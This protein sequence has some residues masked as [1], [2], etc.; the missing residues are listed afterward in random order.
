MSKQVADGDV[1]S[2]GRI[3]ALWENIV[4]SSQA[5]RFSMSN[6]NS[7]SRQSVQSVSIRIGARTGL[8]VK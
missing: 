3:R 5:Q 8:K 1:Q 2:R 7:Y 4:Y 6:V